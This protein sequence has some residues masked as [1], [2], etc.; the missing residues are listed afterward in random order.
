MDYSRESPALSFERDIK[1]FTDKVGLKLSQVI[2]VVS[3][4]LYN[5]ITDK[6]P[7]D[8][9]RARANW[10]ISATTKNQSVTDETK[11]Q[12]VISLSGLK[13]GQ[14]NVVWITNN[15]EYVFS[16]EK[17]SSTQAPNGMVDISLQEVK[18]WIASRLRL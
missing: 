16:L 5:R 8:T 13:E 2:E 1:K 17:G 12:S 9:G 15:L 7:V 3:I 6:T 11:R 14:D 4:E 10:N 18:S